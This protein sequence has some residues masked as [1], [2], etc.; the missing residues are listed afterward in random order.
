MCHFRKIVYCMIEHQRQPFMHNTVFL[1]NTEQM[2]I[3][4]CA[5]AIPHSHGE[6]SR[7]GEHDVSGLQ[8]ASVWGID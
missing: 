3:Q 1:N 2:L 8:H 7:P 6:C 4:V 5:T